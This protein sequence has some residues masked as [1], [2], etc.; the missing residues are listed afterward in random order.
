MSGDVQTPDEDVPQDPGIPGKDVMSETS[1]A[2]LPD[3]KDPAAEERERVDDY[4]DE[5][6]MSVPDA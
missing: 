5:G 4:D 6:H 3:E 1:D 2:D